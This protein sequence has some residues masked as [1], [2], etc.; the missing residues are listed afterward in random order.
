MGKEPFVDASLVKIRESL[1]SSLDET[2]T[3]QEQKR[4][5]PSE[6]SPAREMKNSTPKN[7]GMVIPDKEWKKALFARWDEYRATRRDVL[8]RI[9]S[10]ISRIPEELRDHETAMASLTTAEEKLNSILKELEL[11]DD[12]RWNRSNFSTELGAAMKKVENAR[13]ECIMLENT[14][15]GLPSVNHP[16]TPG[17]GGRDVSFIYELTSISFTQAFKLGFGFFFSLT[18][19]ILLGTF[20]LALFNYLTVN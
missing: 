7:G 13:L 11:L 5:N 16:S 17:G 3:I 15:K 14:G 10:R 1:Q 18:V 20:L 8:V 19:A 6:P 2:E 12:S 4:S 9:R